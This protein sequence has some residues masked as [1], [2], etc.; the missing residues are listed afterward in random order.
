MPL[1]WYQISSNK[2]IFHRWVTDNSIR[3]MQTTFKLRSNDKMIEI[4]IKKKKKKM[5]KYIAISWILC[6]W[7][8]EKLKNLNIYSF[9]FASIHCQHFQIIIIIR[10]LELRVFSF[11]RFFFVYFIIFR[12]TSFQ[13]H[14]SFWTFRKRK[15]QMCPRIHL[16]QHICHSVQYKTKTAKMKMKN[17]KNLC[18]FASIA[19]GDD[20]ISMIPP[21]L[22]RTLVSHSSDSNQWQAPRQLTTRTFIKSERI[23]FFV[24]KKIMWRGQKL[25]RRRCD[26]WATIFVQN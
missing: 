7:N 3:Q 26:R 8:R 19:I 9:L 21:I 16:T 23:K 1:I 13:T 10:I 5:C 20:L 2:S 22:N 12:F 15:H 25:C 11:V 4:I 14:F 18:N 6:E 24:K 17:K